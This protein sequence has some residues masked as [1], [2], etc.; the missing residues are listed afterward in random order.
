[1]FSFLKRRYQEYW[2]THLLVFLL[3]TLISGL[4]SSIPYQREIF[5][6]VGFTDQ[7]K[8]A[9]VQADSILLSANHVPF[10]AVDSYSPPE[11]LHKLLSGTLQDLYS[12][13]RTSIKS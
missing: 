2:K 4:L 12:D 10:G 11:D 6:R 8:G 3:L 1:M 9:G 5:S 13:V 7:V